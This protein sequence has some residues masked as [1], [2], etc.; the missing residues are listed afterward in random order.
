MPTLKQ[1]LFALWQYPL[2]HHALS[3][4]MGNLTHSRIPWLKNLLIRGFSRWFDID[5]NEAVN[6][7]PQDYPC[8]NDFF[9]R[10]LKPGARPTPEDQNIV[11][12]PADGA[13]SQIGTLTSQW[14][15]QAKGRDYSVSALLGEPEIG[16][17]FNEGEFATIY[18]S[19]RDYHRVHMPVSGTLRQM[20]HVP[21][22]LFSVNP[23]TAAAVD[24]LFARNER[25]VCLFDTEAGPM[26]LV[27]VGALL[28]ASIETVWHGVVTPPSQRETRHWH[29]AEGDIRLQ[30]GDEMG[31]FNM[32]STVIILFSREAVRWANP[33]PGRELKMGE[34]IGD[35]TLKSSSTA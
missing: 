10:Q 2:P 27:L 19:P 5:I 13:I 17:P 11:I 9:T 33:A 25:V 23:A 18:L 21:G 34:A 24:N 32:G 7:D 28:V 6:S 3:R 8:F 30:R 29:Y 4:L 26:A 31:R 12:S 16:S 14:L 15:I 22:R 20:I 35:L 1:T